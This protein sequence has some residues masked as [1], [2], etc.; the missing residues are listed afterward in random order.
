MDDINT[1]FEEV[2]AE[3]EKQKKRMDE[4]VKALE[5]ATQTTESLQSYVQQLALNLQSKDQYSQ[6]SETTS[7]KFSYSSFSIW[8]MS[9]QA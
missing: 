6:T 8:W 1:Q 4:Q 9:C 7:I 5:K 2:W 3:I